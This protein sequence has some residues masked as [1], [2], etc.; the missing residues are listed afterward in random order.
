MPIRRVFAVAVLA[1]PCIAACA[2]SQGAPLVA[3]A[4][5]TG[6]NRVKATTITLPRED[7]LPAGAAVIAVP[8]TRTDATKG[9]ASTNKAADALLGG[10]S[11]E[12]SAET[13]VRMIVYPRARSCYAA[14]QKREPRARGRVV[15]AIQV[16]GDGGIVSTT[17][18]IASGLPADTVACIE[19]AAKNVMFPPPGNRGAHVTAPMVFAPE[20]AAADSEADLAVQRTVVPVVHDCYAAA[21]EKGGKGEIEVVVKVGSGGTPDDVRGARDESVGGGVAECTTE[22]LRAAR[23]D[24]A[25]G[26]EITATIVLR[27]ADDAR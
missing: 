10:A 4:S 5:P 22:K 11:G 1:V 7:A 12:T 17:A 26:R 18:E 27:H 15:L 19:G 16:R 21:H 13:V 25:L 6:G 20:D 9:S 8:E 14:L 2:E 23:F 24:A 3:A